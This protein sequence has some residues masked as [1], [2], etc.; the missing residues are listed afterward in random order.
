MYVHKRLTKYYPGNQIKQ[1]EMGGLL[2]E[3]IED[4]G[5]A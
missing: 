5:V 1:T 3:R 4:I 2:L